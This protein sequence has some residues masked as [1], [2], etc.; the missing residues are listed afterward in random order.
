MTRRILL[1]F[2]LMAILVTT[3]LA[4]PLGLSFA[5]RE[6]DRLLNAVERDSRVLAAET[7]DQFETNDF[8]KLPAL[9]DRYVR[10]TH[11]RVVMVNAVGRSVIDS[12]NRT[13]PARDFSTRPE[14]AAALAGRYSSGERAST[15]L[16][17]PLLYVAV[18]IVQE[19]RVLGVVRVSYPTATIDRRTRA[20][21]LQ[22]AGL[23]GV[24][25]VVVVTAGWIVARTL[26]GPVI[27]LETAADGLAAGDLSIRAATDRGPRDLLR[28]ATTF[29][30]MAER[31]ETLVESQRS[32]LADASHQLRTPLTALRLR[33]DA[34]EAQD[35]VVSADVN[36]ALAEVDRL[37]SL[38]DALLAMARVDAQSGSVRP[39]AVDVAALVRDRVD[40]WGSLADE[41]GVTLRV[42]APGVP[43]RADAVA[44][45]LEQIL[46]NLLANAIDVAPDAST[47]TATAA[48]IAGG[49]VE[50]SIADEGPGLTD[51]QIAR[52]FDRFW[53][54]PSATPGGSGLGLAIVRRLAET[55]GGSARIERGSPHGLRVVVTLPAAH[56]AKRVAG[57]TT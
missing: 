14:I 16:G 50:L 12:D 53:R 56:S 55:S 21:W 36:A 24:T 43:V 18:P 10:E 46:D 54:G 57:P 32:F 39:V 35:E 33:L 42:E 7:D 17:A 48:V 49:S 8:T 26:S 3:M 2:A 45:G 28:V 15:T 27:S 19:G 20:V 23:S 41:R 44:G 6:H 13:G 11:G 4:V 38:V 29:N 34:L 40:A 9:V 5:R 52:A 51:A 1:S 31:I 30:N 47:I 22:L 37:S 25:L